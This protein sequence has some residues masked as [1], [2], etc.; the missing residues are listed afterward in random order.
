MAQIDT[1]VLF[2]T[3]PTLEKPSPATRM[4]SVAYILGAAPGSSSST[5]GSSLEPVELQQILNAGAKTIV[6]FGIPG[7][8]VSIDNVSDDAEAGRTCICCN[9]GHRC[10]QEL[11]HLLDRHQRR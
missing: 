3:S 1:P 4:S 10:H 2:S 5:K 9:G 8:E 6:S 11:H 7:P